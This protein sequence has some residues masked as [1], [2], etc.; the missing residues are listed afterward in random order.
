M[1]FFCC[2]RGLMVMVWCCSVVPVA[3]GDGE[4]DVVW[5]MHIVQE[6]NASTLGESRGV[7]VNLPFLNLRPS[8]QPFV[9]LWT[10]MS[11]YFPIQCRR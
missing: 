3:V 2:F 4:G 6:R 10:K 8:Y 1:V 5:N 11:Q 7:M 9:T